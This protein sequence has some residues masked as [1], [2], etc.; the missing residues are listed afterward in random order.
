MPTRMLPNM[1]DCD[2]DILIVLCKLTNTYTDFINVIDDDGNVLSTET[3]VS[4]EYGGCGAE[5]DL[6]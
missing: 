5:I 4:C 2:C 3:I 6:L 1:L